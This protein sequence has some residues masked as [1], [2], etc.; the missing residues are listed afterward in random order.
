MKI[1]VFTETISSDELKRVGINLLSRHSTGKKSAH[2]DLRDRAM[3][4]ISTAMTMRGDNVR[5]ILLSDLMV[6]YVLLSQ[7]RL[8]R[9][10]KVL[11]CDSSWGT[12]VTH[13]LS[14]AL[15]IVSNEGK[16]NINSRL[17]FHAAFRHGHP[18][19]CSV[20]ALAL[21]FFSYF[22]IM[23]YERPDFAPQFVDPAHPEK[24]RQ[25]TWH[26]HRLF[27]V[28]QNDPNE[29]MSP[30]SNFILPISQICSQ[31]YHLNRPPST[32]KCAQAQL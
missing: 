14:K 22:H 21:Y 5:P 28:S 15:V 26:H 20:G 17:D 23:K 25:F 24:G 31:S 8:N 12:I 29:M 4:L 30:Q 16:T 3:L 6:N 7:S 32:S 1:D 13:L 27:P 19:I 9:T 11:Y 10:E 2:L 18:E